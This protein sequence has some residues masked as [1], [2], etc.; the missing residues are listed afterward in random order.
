MSD[1]DLLRVPVGPGALHVE[2][3]GYGGEPVILL[4]GF[5][6]CAFLWRHVAPRLAIAGCSA[7]AVDLLGYG[8]SDRPPDVA[9]GIAEQMDYVEHAMTALRVARA[10]VV[11]VDIGALIALRLAALRPDRV[12]ALVMIGPNWVTDVPGPDVRELQNEAAKLA[13][14]GATGTFAAQPLISKLLHSSVATPDMMPMRLAA[15]F[16]APY[17]GSDGAAQLLTLSQSLTDDDT[18]GI[19]LAGILTPTLV[20]RGTL[21]HWCEYATIERY[22]AALPNARALEI[23]GAGRLV[24]EEAPRALCEDLLVFFRSVETTSGRLTEASPAVDAPGTNHPSA[25]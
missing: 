14:R 3:Y 21:D 1:A 11:G 4:H 16:L 24:P 19:D 9:Y 18:S 8:E 6:T 13:L 5:G 15:R 7:F 10:A 23:R 25:A 17:V 20:L 12:A 2:R 22:A